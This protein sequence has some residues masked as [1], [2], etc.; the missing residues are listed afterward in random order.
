MRLIDQ[1]GANPHTELTAVD[2]AA[3]VAQL[4]GEGK[5]VLLHCVAAQSRTPTVAALY[6]RNHRGI[7][8]DRALDDVIAALPAADPNSEFLSIILTD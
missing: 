6:A 3:T 8:A 2:A 4:R 1:V 5:N 7:P